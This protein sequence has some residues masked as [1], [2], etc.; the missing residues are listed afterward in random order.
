MPRSQVRSD[1]QRD[2]YRLFA[3]FNQTPIESKYN[4]KEMLAGIHRCA[5]VMVSGTPD[6]LRRHDELM[7]A[8]RKL[9]SATADKVDAPTEK[10]LAEM[11]KQIDAIAI[12]A[13]LVMQDMEQ[14]RRRSFLSAGSTT[15]RSTVSSRARRQRFRRRMS[16]WIPRRYTIGLSWPDGS[17]AGKTRCLPGCSKPLVGGGFRR[18]IVSTADDFGNQG[19]RPTHGELLDWLAAEL[20]ENGWSMKHMVRL[21]VTSTAYRQ[22]AR[23]TPERLRAD[24]D[25]V[26]LSRGRVFGCPPR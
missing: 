18:G 2:Y 13:T 23:V 19:E 14:P 1:H 15:L 17:P 26:L 21:M 10:K 8:Y 25:N 16:H 20:Q 4:G 3:Y 5:S 12:V 6:D 7:A 11:R 9:Q 24:P 22:S